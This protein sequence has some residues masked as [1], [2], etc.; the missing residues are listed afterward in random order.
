MPNHKVSTDEIM[1]FLQEHMVTKI[2]LQEFRSEMTTTMD[3]FLTL[4]QKL[5][6][7]RLAMI[8]RHERIE[9]RVEIIEGKLGLS[10][11]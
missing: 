5:D 3:E 1:E 2:E 6:V 7:E 11:S 4:H 9:G 8:N 10:A